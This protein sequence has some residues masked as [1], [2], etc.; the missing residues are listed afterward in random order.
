MYPQAPWLIRRDELHLLE[1]AFDELSARHEASRSSSNWAAEER[2]WQEYAHTEEVVEDAFQR[3]SKEHGWPTEDGVHE[4]IHEPIAETESI[5][6]ML[7]R[8][9]SRDPLYARTMTWARDVSRWANQTYQ[10]AETHPPELYRVCVFAPLVPMKISYALAETAHEGPAM[11]TA[12]EKE[13]R[14]ASQ[15]LR[16]A[17]EALEH[18]HAHEAQT[19]VG[20]WATQ[21]QVLEEEIVQFREKL[22]SGDL[23]VV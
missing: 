11:T 7:H 22:S 23:P 1:D 15:Y 20:S 14:L 8:E 5:A 16:S 21:A 3:V 10:S 17:R 13:L 4:H 6:D 12:V 2:V 18:L 19:R 9:S